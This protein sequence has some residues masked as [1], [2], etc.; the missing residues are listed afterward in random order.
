M[1]NSVISVNCSYQNFTSSTFNWVKDGEIFTPPKQSNEL[2]KDKYVQIPA[3]L[4]E[5][6]LMAINMQGSAPE[7]QGYYHCMVKDALNHTVNST[8]SLVRFRGTKQ[9]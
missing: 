8:K 5:Q 6:R 1:L 9:S 3:Y 4:Q 7:L 2:D